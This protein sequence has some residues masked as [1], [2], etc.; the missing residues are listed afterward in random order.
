[1][2]LK[3]I[4]KISRKT[5]FDPLTWIDYQSLKNL[6]F[7]LFNQIRALFAVPKPQRKETFEQAVKRFGLNVEE[8]ENIKQSY[9]GYA[10]LFLLIS[11]GIGLFSFYLIFHYKTFFGFLIGAAVVAFSLAQAFR[12]DFWAFQIK[13]RKLGCTFAEWK[14]ARF[15]RKG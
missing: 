1:M 12:Y 13:Q 4:F 2:A 15:G 10:I 8:L 5:F 3:D 9:Q 6:N 11:I 7:T 14:Q